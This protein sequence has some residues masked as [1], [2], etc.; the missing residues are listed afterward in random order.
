MHHDSST[1]I[2]I[3]FGVAREEGGSASL[4]RGKRKVSDFLLSERGSY[5]TNESLKS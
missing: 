4:E 3:W 1:Q 5:E 2:R